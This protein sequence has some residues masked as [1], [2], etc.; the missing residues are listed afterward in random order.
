MDKISV[1]DFLNKKSNQYYMSEKIFGILLEKKIFDSYGKK[2]Y[3]KNKFSNNS[4]YYLYKELKNR[5]VKI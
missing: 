5:Y 1:L 4:N 2:Q 3:R